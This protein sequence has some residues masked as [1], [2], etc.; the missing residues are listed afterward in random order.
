MT[1]STTVRSRTRP[2]PNWHALVDHDLWAIVIATTLAFVLTLLIVHTPKRATVTIANDT[3]YQLTIDATRPGSDS[4]SPV[5]VI[6]PDQTQTRSVVDQG[7][8]WVVRFSGQGQSGG[9]I[10][11]NRS[12]IE[13]AGWQ[14]AVPPDIA[15]TLEEAGATP[16]PR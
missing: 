3:A 4:W 16:P 10:T 9:E 12:D 14:F 8:V 7:D 15:L 5:V 1:P 11:V 2:T 6:E 13:R